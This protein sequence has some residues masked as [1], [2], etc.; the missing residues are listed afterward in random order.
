MSTIVPLKLAV[1]VFGPVDVGSL[2][3]CSIG[4]RLNTLPMLDVIEPFSFVDSTIEV[5][6][7][8]VAIC[9]IISPGALI[10]IP[11]GVDEAP[12]A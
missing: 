9:F 11:I 5:H 12:L 2:I 10:Y 4:P 3:A 7:L 8:P 6:V 1:A